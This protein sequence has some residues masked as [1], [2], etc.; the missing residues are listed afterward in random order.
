MRGQ[1]YWTSSKKIIW[2]CKHSTNAP[3][4]LEF[5]SNFTLPD[6][7]SLILT[8]PKAFGPGLL[9]ILKP[10]VLTVL[11]LL[12]PVFYKETPPLPTAVVKPSFQVF[13]PNFTISYFPSTSSL[14]SEHYTVASL[15]VPL[16]P[17]SS[18]IFFSNS[19][20]TLSLSLSL[21]PG[22]PIQRILQF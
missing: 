9:D 7:K 12:W 5:E 14:T 19:V 17:W 11:T 13:L 16:T 18:F 2:A 8:I 6:P 15:F 10:P 21:N 3:N 4:W 22:K 20:R 1:P